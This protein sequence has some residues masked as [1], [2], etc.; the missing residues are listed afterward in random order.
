[1][2]RIEYFRIRF[3]YRDFPNP[4]RLTEVIVVHGKENILLVISDQLSKQGSSIIL[5]KIT[6]EPCKEL[7]K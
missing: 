7:Y 2:R 6:I 4:R 5:D 1:M 3:D